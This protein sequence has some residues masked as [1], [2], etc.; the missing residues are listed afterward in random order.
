MKKQ[1]AEIKTL[2]TVQAFKKILN[3]RGLLISFGYSRFDAAN[4]KRNHKSGGV[5]INKMHEVIKACGYKLAQEE[6]WIKSNK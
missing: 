2:T 3:E 4:L 5:T 1:K 6:L